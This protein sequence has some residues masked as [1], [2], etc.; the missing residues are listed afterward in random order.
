MS[1]LNRHSVKETRRG[2]DGICK[3]TGNSTEREWSQFKKKKFYT[4][5]VENHGNK[6]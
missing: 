2:K 4:E 6:N 1:D 5:D 3:E